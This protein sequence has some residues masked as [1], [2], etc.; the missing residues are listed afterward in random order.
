MT[1][2]VLTRE[3]KEAITKALKDAERLRK[4]LQRAKRAGIDVTEL[5]NRLREAELSLRN[6]HRVYVAGEG[7]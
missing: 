1:E 7:R 4:E 2:E 3:D 6:L 5:E